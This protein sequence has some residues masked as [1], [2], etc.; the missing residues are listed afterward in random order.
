[1]ELYVDQQKEEHILNVLIPGCQ[2]GAYSI[3]NSSIFPFTARAKTNLALLVLQREDMLSLVDHSEHLSDAIE[4]ATEFIIDS[5]V[6]LCDYT[7]PPDPHQMKDMDDSLEGDRGSRLRKRFKAAVERL[8]VL[9][10]GRALKSLKLMEL[11]D[12]M[13]QHKK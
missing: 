2:I 13:K 3:I 8:R 6:P 10:K 5:E 4:E 1:M 11:L 12:M 9:H 7:I